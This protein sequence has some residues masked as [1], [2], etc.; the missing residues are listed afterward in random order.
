[1]NGT[2]NAVAED[3]L[4]RE[5]REESAPVLAGLYIPRLDVTYLPLPKCGHYSITQTLFN[6]Y[7]FEWVEE[8]KGTVVAMIRAPRDRL[9]SFFWYSR[10]V[11]QQ[12]ARSRQI[13]VDSFHHFITTQAAIPDEQRNRHIQSQSRLLANWKVDHFCRWD[14]LELADIFQVGM[15]GRLNSSVAKMNPWGEETLSL[16]DKDPDWAKDAG[17][18]D[19]Y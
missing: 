17:L 16:V 2:A 6:A 9:E 13:P 1:M 18:F 7:R 5:R 19:G 4:S 14:W 12:F 10:T 8:A 15:F 11:N 3:L